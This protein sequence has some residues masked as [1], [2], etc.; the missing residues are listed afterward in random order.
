MTV[1]MSELGTFAVSQVGCA[2]TYAYRVFKIEVG[3]SSS[4]TRFSGGHLLAALHAPNNNESKSWLVLYDK[5][6]KGCA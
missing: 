3:F 6:E 5:T 1:Y 4:L 2:A